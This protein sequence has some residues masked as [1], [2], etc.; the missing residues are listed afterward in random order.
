M[1]IDAHCHIGEIRHYNIDG[2]VSPL[3]H[4]GFMTGV[5]DPPF[6]ARTPESDFKARRYP[7]PLA[8]DVDRLVKRMD[9]AGVDKT[10][11]VPIDIKR[12]KTKVPNEYVAGK[13][14]KY[15]DRLIG[16]ASV[17]PIGGGKSVRE[18]TEAINSLGLQ[19]LKLL[20]S[21][22]LVSPTDE[23]IFPLYEAAID[24]DIPVQIHTGF[25]SV[26]MMKHETPL[27]IDE[28]A[29]RYPKLRIQMLHS[30]YQWAYLAPMLML[31]HPNV[32]ADISWWHAWPLD[33][34]VRLLGL[35]KHFR[36]L[37]KLMWGTD[38]FDHKADIERVRR[39]PEEAS[40]L[41]V[42]PGLPTITDEDI[43]L[44]LG[45]NAAKFYRVQA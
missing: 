37:N 4:A 24:L 3:D 19:G 28:I 26:G 8:V 13:V 39:V 21:Y 41:D 23:R 14:K 1:I 43:R 11:V 31:K 16:F 29:M 7:N 35:C 9:E 45:E 25:S 27:L 36:V 17:D 2:W 44:I 42:A 12:W 34:L 30:G 32:W 40:R 18:L 6:M 5:Q 22:D 15:P 38:N 20:P 10:V 33:N